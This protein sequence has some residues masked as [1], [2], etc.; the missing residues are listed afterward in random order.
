MQ[1][2]VLINLQ[3]KKFKIIVVMATL[4]PFIE[5]AGRTL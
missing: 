2:Q 5:A 1:K 4:R 3:H